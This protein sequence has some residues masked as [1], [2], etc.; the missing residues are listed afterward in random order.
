LLYTGSYYGTFYSDTPTSDLV[1]AFS[2]RAV[3]FEN[4]PLIGGREGVG[5]RCT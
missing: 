5:F 2:S 1:R 4:L 3:A